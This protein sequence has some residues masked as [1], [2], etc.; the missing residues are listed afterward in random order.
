MIQRDNQNKEQTHQHMLLEPTDRISIEV[1]QEIRL[2]KKNN[3]LVPGI[4]DKGHNE[5][6]GTQSLLVMFGIC[7]PKFY[8]PK[9][10]E[11]GKS[12]YLEN[13]NVVAEYNQQCP[14]LDSNP[15]QHYVV[16]HYED[17]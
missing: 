1:S 4:V 10:M 13:C 11:P 2:I 14:I 6:L 17:C 15:I 16:V 3:T 9:V 7:E 12:Y 5:N 8:E